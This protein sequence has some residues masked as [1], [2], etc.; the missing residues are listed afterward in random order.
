MKPA[1]D[2]VTDAET[3]KYRARHHFGRA[4][5]ALTRALRALSERWPD[6]PPP[7]C[8]EPVF[9]AELV[10]AGECLRFAALS[11]VHH[12]R[13]VARAGVRP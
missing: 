8:F 13:A 10:T 12:D 9:V 3:Y 7:P 11:L 6:R 2:G 4:L 5:A 1:L